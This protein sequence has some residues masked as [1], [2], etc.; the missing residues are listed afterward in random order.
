MNS[1]C[2]SMGGPVLLYLIGAIVITMIKSKPVLVNLNHWKTGRLYEQHYL[3]L[4]IGR[5]IG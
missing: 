5:P 4:H 1:S 3:P 2:G